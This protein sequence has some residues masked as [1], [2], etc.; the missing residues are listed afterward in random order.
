M[1]LSV[2]GSDLAAIHHQGFGDFARETAPG[3]I[4]LFRRARVPRGSTVVDLGCGSGILLRKLDRAGFTTTGIELSPALARIAREV[5]P[6]AEIRVGSIHR[7]AIPKANA[8]TALG[9]VLS[10][11]PAPPLGRTF[12]R[13]ASALEPGGIFVF[14]LM[15]RQRT[16]ANYRAWTAGSTW[17]VAV[18]VRENAARTRLVR[19]IETFRKVDRH[20]HRGR[21]A[22]RIRVVTRDSAL[23]ALERAG[24]RARAVNRF[25]TRR[26]AKGRLGFVAI[27]RRGAP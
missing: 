22:H 8:I 14:D 4:A 5:A 11:L 6:L 26:L 17:L 13:V 15:V 12:R 24:F 3:I 1:F 16:P 19:E 7:S 23:A 10:Y 21:E 9:E 18:A 20:Y 27:K 25:G 2:Y